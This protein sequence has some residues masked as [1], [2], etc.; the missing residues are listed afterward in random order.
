MK[1]YSDAHSRTTYKGVWIWLTEGVYYYFD[2]HMNK[3]SFD[4]MEAAK[5]SL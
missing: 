4:S 1:K 3:I 5:A 2:S